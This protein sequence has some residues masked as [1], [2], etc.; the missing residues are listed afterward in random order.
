MSSA[1]LTAG[2]CWSLQF[3]AR[4]SRLPSRASPSVNTCAV[5]AVKAIRLT[6][7]KFFGAQTTTA[8]SALAMKYSISAAW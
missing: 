6:Q 7:A 2:A 5:P 1:C 8:G 3:A 4:S